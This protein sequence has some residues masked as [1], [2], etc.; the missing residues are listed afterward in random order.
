MVVAEV[1]VAD[2]DAVRL[3][4]MAQAEVLVAARHHAWNY[5]YLHLL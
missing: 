4:L 1:G 2:V 5:G 3:R